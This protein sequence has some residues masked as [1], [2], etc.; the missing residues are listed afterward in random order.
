MFV[1]VALMLA[2]SYCSSNIR[3][4]RTRDKVEVN[5]SCSITI[6]VICFLFPTRQPVVMPTSIPSRLEQEQFHADPQEKHNWKFSTFVTIMSK[7]TSTAFGRKGK[8][9]VLI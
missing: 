3:H 4:V 9:G 2:I 1:V 7:L 8:V 5:H 6:F